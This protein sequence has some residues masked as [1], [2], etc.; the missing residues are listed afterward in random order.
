M[1]ETIP[2][3]LHGSA[4]RGPLAANSSLGVRSGKRYDSFSEIPRDELDGEDSLRSAK[5]RGKKK[6]K[7]RF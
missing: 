1:S 5:L 3:F 7:I 2:V 6:K 4:A